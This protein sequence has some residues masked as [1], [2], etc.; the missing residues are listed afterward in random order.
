MLFARDVH[1]IEDHDAILHDPARLARMRENIKAG[2]TYIAKGLFPKDLLV[3]I[4]EYLVQVGRG[5]LPNYQSIKEGCPNFHRMNRW[6]PRAHVRGCFHQF[7]FFPW[8]DDLFDLFSLFRPVYEM[9]N[10]LSDL[11]AGRFLKQTPEDGCIARLAFQFYPRGLGGLNK[12]VDPVDRHQLTVPTML[13]SQKGEDFQEGGAYVEKEDG[14]R[15]FLDDI[16]SW[17]DVVYFNAQIC[18]GVERID[19]EVRP[20]WPSFEGRWMLLFAVNRLHDN[21]TIADS[22]DLETAQPGA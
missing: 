1:V 16:S 4:R 12:H 20:N 11:P 8:N 19:P 13:L 22:V 9:K 15:I 2:D 10:L 7:V 6:D 14:E 21:R 18:H 3:T 5:S 17:G